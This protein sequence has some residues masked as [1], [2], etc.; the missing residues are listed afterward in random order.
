L[1]SQ[2]TQILG[3]CCKP[4]LHVR[5]DNERA[6]YVYRSLGFSIRMPVYFYVIKKMK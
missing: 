1:L 2:L 3:S 6:I 4:Y 5:T